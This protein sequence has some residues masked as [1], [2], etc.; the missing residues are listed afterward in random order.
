MQEG[1]TLQFTAVTPWKALVINDGEWS[2]EC[3]H[4]LGKNDLVAAFGQQD[5]QRAGPPL[6]NALCGHCDNHEKDDC[7]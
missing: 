7:I 3:A 5:A 1:L 2:P 6:R 4:K